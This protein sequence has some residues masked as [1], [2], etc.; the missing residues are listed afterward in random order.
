MMVLV[1]WQN[2][3][4]TH[5]EFATKEFAKTL[6]S[7]PRVMHGS[8]KCSGIKGRLKPTSDYCCSKCTRG[9]PGRPD[10]LQQISL[11]VGQNLEC[12]DKF[13]Y[14]GDTIAAG[15][16]AGEASR[17]RV[18]CAW[19]KFRELAPILTS[20]GASL[21]VKGRVYKTC[22]QSVLLYGSETWPVTTDYSG[23]AACGKSGTYDDPVDVWCESQEEN[24]KRGVVWALG[25][26]GSHSRYEAWSTEMVWTSRA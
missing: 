14:L 3:E 16:G 1:R 18:R 7:A 2:Q 10:V 5:V 26:G 12:V 9:D 23:C 19:A 20:R 17:A 25:C 24:T 21:K 8:I 15:G 13:C 6:Y 11:D 22:V 4:N